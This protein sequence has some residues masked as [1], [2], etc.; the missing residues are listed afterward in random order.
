MPNQYNIE[1]A[2]RTA[3]KLGL[4]GSYGAIQGAS[5]AAM[6]NTNNTVAPITAPLFPRNLCTNGERVCG[7]TARS[8]IC[9]AV[10][11]IAVIKLSS[12]VD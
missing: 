8:T 12:S 9:G 7:F 1:G 6:M 3:R 5:S 4:S 2:W 11:A 10:K